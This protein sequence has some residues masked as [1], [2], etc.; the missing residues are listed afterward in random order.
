MMTEETRSKI[1][2][3]KVTIRVS[4]GEDMIEVSQFGSWSEQKQ[5]VRGLQMQTGKH[6]YCGATL[7]IKRMPRYGVIH[8]HACGLRLKFPDTIN[9]VDDLKKYFEG[10]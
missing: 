3:K 1:G 5:E 6:L 4:R 7:T 2:Y 8:C 10:P 9:N